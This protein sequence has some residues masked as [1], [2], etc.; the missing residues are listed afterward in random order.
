M[1]ECKSEKWVCVNEAKIKKKI[2]YLTPQEDA[3]ALELQYL[4][5]VTVQFVSGL[6][7]G[8]LFGG[9]VKLFTRHH[10]VIW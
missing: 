7:A 10:D 9:A 5:K 4:S 3:T 6:G 2:Y 8:K 1:W